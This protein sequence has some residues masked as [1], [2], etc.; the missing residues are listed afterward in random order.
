MELLTALSSRL[1]TC[2]TGIPIGLN[3]SGP[4]VKPYPLKSQ[5]VIPGNKTLATWQQKYP[6]KAQ[7]D[8]DR[9]GSRQ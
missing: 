6:F 3:L 2:I 7:R 9:L 5:Q 4:V 1:N 8:V